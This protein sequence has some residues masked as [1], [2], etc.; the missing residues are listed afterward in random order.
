VCALQEPPRPL[1]LPLRQA[2]GRTPRRAG[3]AAARGG[4]PP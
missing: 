4:P 1:P 3:R 2:S